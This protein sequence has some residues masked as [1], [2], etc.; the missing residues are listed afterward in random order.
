MLYNR[1]LTSK[2]IKENSNK[3]YNEA[4]L[5]G[6]DRVTKYCEENGIIAIFQKGAEN[7]YDSEKNTIIINSNMTPFNQLAILLHEIGHWLIDKKGYKHRFS[8]GYANPPKHKNVRHKIDI[9]DEEF[10]AW[11]K[12]WSLGIKLRAISPAHKP[13]W[14]DI[15][16][17]LLNSYIKWAAIS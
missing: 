11:A 8:Y 3:P 12:A 1:K 15:K 5:D 13:A 6:L 14:D 2:K 4:A 17:R 7:H 10:T 16:N 9:I